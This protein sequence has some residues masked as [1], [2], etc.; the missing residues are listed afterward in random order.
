MDPLTINFSF[1]TDLT[2]F[3]QVRFDL[4]VENHFFKE[5]LLRCVCEVVCS[6]FGPPHIGSY[7]IP[8]LF[9]LGAT[10]KL[11]GATLKL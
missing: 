6:P 7:K 4:F 10:L 9:F 1:K 3:L 2:V 11:L 8:F 5:R